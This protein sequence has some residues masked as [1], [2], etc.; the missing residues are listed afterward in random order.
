MTTKLEALEASKRLAIQNAKFP[1]PGLS[2]G[3]MGE[4]MFD[5]L[6][7]E[8]ANTAKQIEVSVAVGLAMNTKLKILLIRRG[9][10]LDPNSLK[11]VADLAAKADA[12]VWLE[13]SRTD[14]PISVIMEDGHVQGAQTEPAAE[15]EE[16]P[17]A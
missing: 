17:S 4:V 3:D 14:V 12:Q 7:F 6:P 5:G 10:D 11:L 16:V 9:S 2:L 1:V 13:T 15:E 8:Q